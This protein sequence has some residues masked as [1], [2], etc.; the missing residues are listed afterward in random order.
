MPHPITSFGNA[1]VVNFISNNNITARGFHATY[2]AS[3]SCKSIRCYFFM[4]LTFQKMKRSF[5]S[6]S[7]CLLILNLL[8]SHLT[9][10]PTPQQ[11]HQRAEEERYKEKCFL[12]YQ[13]LCLCQAFL[14]FFKCHPFQA[15]AV[16]F[17]LQPAG[18]LSTWTEELSTALAIL[19]H[20]HTTA[21]VS[22][23]SSAPLATGSSCPSCKC[24]A[25]G[26]YSAFN[27]PEGRMLCVY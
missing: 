21:S 14:L 10:W 22:G 15:S 19:S 17:L 7:L 11:V 2:A 18:V 16:S 12:D 8:C 5:T 24:I 26:Y 13:M 27:R 9:F 3:S 20:I 23:Q 6:F 4:P 1:L 25:R